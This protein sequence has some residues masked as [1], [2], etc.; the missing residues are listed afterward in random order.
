M[1]TDLAVELVVAAALVVVAGLFASA[2]SA[3]SSI[4]RVR[5]SELVEEGR[6]GAQRLS[7]V[8][9]DPPSLMPTSEPVA[10]LLP[11]TR[12]YAGKGSHLRGGFTL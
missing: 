6:S 9:Q 5:A 7:T 11:R 3:V 2:E 1:S 10:F 8:V 4:S 12:A